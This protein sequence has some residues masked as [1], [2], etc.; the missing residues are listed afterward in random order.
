MIWL[1]PLLLLTAIILSETIGFE[2]S[3]IICWPGRSSSWFRWCS[4]A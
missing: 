4:S 1:R 3:N 2:V